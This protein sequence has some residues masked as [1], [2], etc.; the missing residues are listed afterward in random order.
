M[1]PT[2]HVS[3][4]SD[5]SKF[6]ILLVATLKNSGISCHEGQSFLQ[7][8]AHSQ[9]MPEPCDAVLFPWRGHGRRLRPDNAGQAQRT[10]AAAV[11]SVSVGSGAT[12]RARLRSAMK[13][14]TISALPRISNKFSKFFR[15]KARC[16]ATAGKRRNYGGSTDKN[17]SKRRKKT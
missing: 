1:N 13:V 15:P 6:R 5:D 4:I 3:I 12:L 2:K 10:Y 17:A 7:T 14:S 16:R 11:F 9:E 8:L